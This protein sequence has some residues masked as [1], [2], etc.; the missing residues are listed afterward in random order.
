MERETAQKKGFSTSKYVKSGFQGVLLGGRVSV[1]SKYLSL[2][3][4]WV[5]V[6]VWS[7]WKGSVSVSFGQ[8]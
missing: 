8:C 1:R 4:V 2:Q 7:F 3:M 6:R 5:W